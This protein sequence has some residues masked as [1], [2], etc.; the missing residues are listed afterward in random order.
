MHSA[1]TLG[2]VLTEP[3]LEGLRSP[4]HEVRQ[5]KHQQDAEEAP[6]DTANENG[7]AATVIYRVN[8]S[9]IDLVEKD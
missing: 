1:V 3:R 9:Q 7:V 4:Q 8:L 5:T 2:S 6:N